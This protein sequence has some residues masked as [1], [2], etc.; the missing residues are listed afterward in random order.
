MAALIISL[1]FC[2]C[3]G[4]PAEV[5]W[6]M[7]PKIIRIKAARPARGRAHLKN[8]WIKVCG[9]VG[10]QPRAVLTLSP[11]VQKGLVSAEIC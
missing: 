11:S 6:L 2:C 8:A 9:S 10:M 7:A 4:L 3:S 5:I 1:A